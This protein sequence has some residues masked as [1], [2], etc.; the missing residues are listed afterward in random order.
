MNRSFF[1]IICILTST[2]TGCKRNGEKKAN[3][4]DEYYSEADFYLVKKIDTHIHYNSTDTT[5][6]A[7][8][9]RDNFYLLSLNVDVAGEFPHIRRQRE[10][11]VAMQ[12]KFPTRFK[13]ATAFNVDDWLEPTWSDSTIKYL[14]ESFKSGAVGVKV[15]KNV[16]MVLKDEDAHFVH[17]DDKKF[18]PVINFISNQNKT[19]VGHIGE[20]RN[21]WLPI[22][23]MTVGGDRNY[24]SEHPEFHMN[25]HPEY[26][27][28]EEIISHR[29]NM[30]AN[31][32]NLRFV[33]A[34]LG[35]LE[36]SIDELAKRFDDYPNLAVD[37]AERICH[38]QHQAVSDWSSVRAFLIKYQDRFVYGT[39]A[40]IE[41]TR[42]M[43]ALNKEYHELR[44]Q[45]WAFFTS[46]DT[47]TNSNVTGKFKGMQLPRAV[48]EKIYRKNAQRV[49]ALGDFGE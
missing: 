19:L 18:E 22:E 24:F 16:G 32:Q 8:A 7:G 1:I 39:D 5:F 36:W 20:P 40:I 9:T 13:Y 25:K 12:N 28:Y 29:D 49:F 45:D 30:L 42:N 11:A 47:L 14:D 33:G 41:D 3:E 17:I 10:F 38:L 26:P 4:A 44:L 6:L 31:H 34:H 15:W 35:S 23:E 27:S 21:C 43:Q 48:V 46:A 2:L 37:L